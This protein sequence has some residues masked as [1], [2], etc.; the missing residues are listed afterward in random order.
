[1][2]EINEDNIYVCRCEEVTVGDIKRAIAEGADSLKAIKLRTHATMGVCQGMTC[3]KN[4][5][6]MLREKKVDL[7]LCHGYSQRFP[8]RMMNV[9]DLA[10]ILEDTDESCVGGE[11]G[12]HDN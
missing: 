11:E 12:G 4:I 2:S 6:K 3:R 5:E 7:D 9:G 10:G 8:V 1:M